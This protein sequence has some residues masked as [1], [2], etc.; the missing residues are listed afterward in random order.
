MRLSR[1]QNTLAD[2]AENSDD[3]PTAKLAAEA[4]YQVGRLAN[5]V[6]AVEANA[7]PKLA[8][9]KERTVAAGHVTGHVAKSVGHTTADK[10]KGVGRFTKSIPGAFKGAWDE[11]K[12][13]A[14]ELE[15]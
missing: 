4:N 3:A 7:E 6:E 9:V 14:D 2:L 11:A 13:V 12:T 1:I 10:A 15:A 8:K 5:R